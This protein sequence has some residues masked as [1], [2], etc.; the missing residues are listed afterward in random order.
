MGT[1]AAYIYIYTIKEIFAFGWAGETPHVYSVAAIETGPCLDVS[2]CYN[3][4]FV[5]YTRKRKMFDKYAKVIH[6]S[7]QNRV[8]LAIKIY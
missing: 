4:A 6:H 1:E 2:F 5:D 3:S 8:G 7:D